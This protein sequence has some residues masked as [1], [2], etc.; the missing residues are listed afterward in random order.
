MCWNEDVSLN[1][2]IFSFF[3]LILII[4]NN[5]YTR[6]KI[7]ELDNPF[8]YIFILSIIS[9]Q[10]LEYFLWKHIDDKKI[11]HLLSLIGTFIIYI[12]PIAALFLL[13]NTEK[14]NQFISIYLLSL[15][16]LIYKLIHT[17][18][19]SKIS[20]KGHL[21]WNWPNMS[22]LGIMYIL[23]LFYPMI[24][25]QHYGISIATFGLL[26]LSIYSYGEDNSYKSM[27]CWYANIFMLLFAFKLVIYLPYKEHYGK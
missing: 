8:A 4:Y 13:K 20:K 14:R 11:N 24:V 3:V 1:T 7:K 17:N 9:I 15:P 18:V 2:F 22:V 10:L 12:Q 21:E 5:K 26:M 16:L 19:I 25:S 6:Y 23:F 27:W